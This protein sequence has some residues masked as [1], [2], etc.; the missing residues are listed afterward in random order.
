[1]VILVLMC[2]LDSMECSRGSLFDIP[3]S[4]DYHIP[5]LSDIPAV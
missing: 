2:H 4:R 5:D 3:C 1:V